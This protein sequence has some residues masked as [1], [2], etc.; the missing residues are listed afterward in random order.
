MK[1]GLV[2]YQGGGKSTLF[3]LLTG[4][5]PDPSKVQSG[6]VGMATVPD[7]RFDR[8]VQFYQ[9]KKLVPTKVEL[10][11]TPGLSRTEH[12]LNAQRLGIIREAAAMVQVIGVFA[13]HNPVA[14]AR[15]FEDDLI[16]ADLQVV[17]NRIERLKKDI[18][19]PRPDRDQLNE[20]L[21]ALLPVAA[22]LNDGKLLVDFK[23]SEA[24]E[25][26]VKSFALLSRK[27]RMIVLNTAEVGTH[28]AETKQLE[29][30]GYS[31]LTAPIGLD[32]ELQSLPPADRDE[33]A[34]E[35]GL[36]HS[37]RE[38]LLRAV[39]LL[40]GQI[41][42]YTCNEKEVHAWLLKR[43]ATAVEAADIIH[44]DLARGFVRAEVMAVD[45]LLRLGSE[46]EVKAAGL[47]RVEGKEYLVQD[48]DEIVIR[49]GV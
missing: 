19:K 42:F 23:F 35:M 6:Q 25:K 38:T 31:V 29:Q 3:K 20:E 9:P 36:T 41:T 46:R 48:G 5:E 34:R 47:Y 13:G 1:V 14:D 15:A 45:D 16:L 43:G 7:E 26:A 21:N 18:A 32:L 4:A 28:Q 27:A 24:Q 10:F 11:D 49:S 12:A 8:L 17:N 30:A 37:C 39:F 33:F 40:T 44:S 2:G 22:Q